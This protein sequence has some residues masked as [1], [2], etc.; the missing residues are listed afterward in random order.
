MPFRLPVGKHFAALPFLSR[1]VLALPVK[2]GFDRP[3][4]LDYRS[5]EWQSAAHRPPYLAFR[6]LPWRENA[7]TRT[8]EHASDI[9]FLYFWHSTSFPS[10]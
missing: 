7:N 4:W 10:R 6:L 5:P 1:G 8:P 9:R 2:F 3:S